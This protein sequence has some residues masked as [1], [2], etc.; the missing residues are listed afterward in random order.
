MVHNERSTVDQAI[1]KERATLD[2]L[3]AADKDTTALVVGTQL[4]IYAYNMFQFH[5]PQERS[6]PLL[7]KFSS[8]FKLSDAQ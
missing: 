7:K 2:K 3:G 1:N 4:E 8:M 5:C 6:R